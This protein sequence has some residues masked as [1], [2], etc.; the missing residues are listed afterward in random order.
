MWSIW[1]W[2]FPSG[3]VQVYLRTFRR[4]SI[5]ILTTRSIDVTR[6][7]ILTPLSLVSWCRFSFPVVGLKIFSISNFALKS[8][9]LIPHKSSLEL[10]LFSSLGTCTLQT[11]ILNQ[12]PI[13]TT[14][15]AL[16]LT[17]STLLTADTILWC[18]KILFPVDDFRFLFRWKNLKILSYCSAPFST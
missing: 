17:K 2:V 12:Q 7:T 16:S 18:K 13:R 4:R 1:L 5:V 9:A 8:P 3:E 14:Y 11:I 10:S 6:F 15:G